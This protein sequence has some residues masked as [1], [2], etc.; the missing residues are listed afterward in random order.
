MVLVSVSKFLINK[1]ASLEAVVVYTAAL[2]FQ[3]IITLFIHQF[4]NAI[5]RSFRQSYLI[6]YYCLF[7][8]IIFNKCLFLFLFY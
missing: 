5:F 4:F 3:K 1:F 2:F 8:D 7:V 6:S